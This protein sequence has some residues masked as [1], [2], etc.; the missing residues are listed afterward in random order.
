MVKSALKK[1][2]ARREGGTEEGE[3]ERFILGLILNSEGPSNKVTFEWRPKGR[4]RSV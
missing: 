3:R 1:N 2:K 4:E